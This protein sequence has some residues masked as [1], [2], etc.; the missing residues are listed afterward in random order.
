MDL[1]RI[2]VTHREDFDEYL[3]I[4]V[5]RLSTQATIWSKVKMELQDYFENT[6]GTGI[7]ATADTDGKVDVAIY[8]RPHVFEADTIGLIMRDRLSHRNLQTNPY[9][10]YMFIEK[11]KGYQGK[12]LYLQKTREDTD[13]EVI[14]EIRRK[15]K[16]EYSDSSDEGTYLVYFRVERV[17]PLVGDKA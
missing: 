11:G 2:A 15:P 1:A 14:E 9:A 17:R 5:A 6:E 4:E 13:P 3:V 16:R 12:R 10:A 8:A 7:L